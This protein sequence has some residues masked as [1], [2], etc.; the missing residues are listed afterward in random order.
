MKDTN[1]KTWK[2]MWQ[3]KEY[4]HPWRKQRHIIEAMNGREK[5]ESSNNKKDE[6]KEG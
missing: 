3:D 2:E 6:G 5:G 1:D 4:K